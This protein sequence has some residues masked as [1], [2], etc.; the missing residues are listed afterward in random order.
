MTETYFTPSGSQRSIDVGE[1][2][3]VKV[4]VLGAGCEVGR[5][6]IIVE[7]CHRIIMLDCGIHPGHSGIGALPVFDGVDVEAINLCLITHFHLDHCGALPYLVS[8]TSFKGKV[9]M[10]EPTKS[11][12]KL[13]WLDYATMASRG[14]AAN[15][16]DLEYGVTNDDILFTHDDINLCMKSIT[17]IQFRETIEYPDLD[18]QVC[19]YAAGHVLGAAM[20]YILINGIG[21][22][23]T[24]IYNTHTVFNSMFFIVGDFSREVDRHVPIAEIPDVPVHVVIC[25]STYGIRVHEPR[26]ER[27]KRFLNSV[28]RILQRSGKVL[29]P[30]FALGR[31]QV[32]YHIFTLILYRPL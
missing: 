1:H 6:C 7:Y 15:S 14:G 19:C 9:L 30:I 3:E 5:S 16:Y 12:G 18:I 17:T 8:K 31:V 11:I 23:Y 21:I 24:G 29:M 25:E 20:F 4:T 13:L 10:T 22:L 26:I 2:S 32:I 27:E 28:C